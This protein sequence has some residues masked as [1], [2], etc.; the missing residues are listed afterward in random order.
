MDLTAEIGRCRQN[1]TERNREMHERPVYPVR[2]RLA[3]YHPN[4][5][6][7]GGA[8]AFELSPAAG[9]EEGG[10][11]MTMVSQLTVGDRRA[12]EPTFPT[13]DWENRI[14]VF[15]GFS[16]LCKLLQVLRGEC[17]S[18]ENGKGVFHQSSRFNTKITF[19]HLV[20]P[21]QGYSLEVFRSEIK[22][23]GEWRSHILIS[24]WEAVG[25]AEA[26]AGAMTYVSFGVPVMPPARAEISAAG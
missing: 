25:L 6:C 11:F 19:R 24:P 20:E 1:K 3:F 16:D 2:P 10:V 9:R 18:L 23:Q 5:K 26:L 22:G 15:L 17:E 12:P 4:G 21:V 7:T 14:T 8:V 13:F